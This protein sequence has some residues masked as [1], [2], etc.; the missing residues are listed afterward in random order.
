MIIFKIQPNYY[1]FRP[2][3]NI[4]IKYATKVPYKKMNIYLIE[5]ETNV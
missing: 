3:I 4:M 1:K 5:K 2:L